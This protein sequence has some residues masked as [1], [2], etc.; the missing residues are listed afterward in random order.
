MS[1]LKHTEYFID[2]AISKQDYEKYTPTKIV[3]KENTKKLNTNL[4]KVL[5]P[6]S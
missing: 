6:K 4:E 3:Q 5:K 2:N 1:I